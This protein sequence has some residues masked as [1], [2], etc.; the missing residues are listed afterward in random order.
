MVVI[1]PWVPFLDREIVK[2][3]I[4]IYRER[5][6]DYSATPLRG[7]RIAILEPLLITFLT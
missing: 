1:R 6:Q 4:Y 3:Y 5:E 7:S 2:T